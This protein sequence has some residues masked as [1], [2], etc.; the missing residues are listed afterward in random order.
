MGGIVYAIADYLE[1]EYYD[2]TLVTLRTL[3][4]NSNRLRCDGVKLLARCLKINKSTNVRKYNV[5]GYVTTTKILEDIILHNKKCKKTPF[6]IFD[7]NTD[8]FTQDVYEDINDED[9]PKF[10]KKN[11]LTL[12]YKYKFN[13]YLNVI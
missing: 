2:N 10:F 8:K 13:I 5:N 6:W 12:L 9:K 3:K 4:L 7:E 1:D 11:L